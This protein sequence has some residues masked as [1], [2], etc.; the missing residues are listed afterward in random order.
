MKILLFSILLVD[1]PSHLP[2]ADGTIGYYLP[3]GIRNVTAVFAACYIRPMSYTIGPSTLVPLTY[4]RM[5]L[6][7]RINPE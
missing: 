4:C 7:K 3:D 2:R 5:S 6:A 1:T